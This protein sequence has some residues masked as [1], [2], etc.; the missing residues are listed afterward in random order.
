MRTLALALIAAVAFSGSAE[1]PK[2][3]CSEAEQ[4]QVE[5]EAVTLRSWDAFY[6]S[7]RRYRHCDDVS[8]AE[9]YSESI[10]R[11]LADHWRTL[12]R[13]KQ[14]ID[15]DKAFGNFVTINASMNIEDVAKIRD[16]ATNRCPAGLTALCAK[17]KRQ[18]DNA[19]A[20]HASFHK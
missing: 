4:M 11:I 2:R 10:A 19:I 18:T 3:I 5:K 16:Y 20:E 8:A 12:P 14:L 1:T 13:L 7:Y 15:R 9:G 6:K 17:L